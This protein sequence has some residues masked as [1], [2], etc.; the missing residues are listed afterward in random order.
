MMRLSN[1]P[2]ALFPFLDHPA[3]IAYAHRGGA[4]EGE[5]NT[6]PAFE[7]ATALGYTH[8]ET[9]IRASR[10]GVGVVFHDRMLYRVTGHPGP[11]SDYNWSTLSQMRTREGN[12]LLRLDDLL[13]AFPDTFINL[14][15]KS[16]AAVEP[17]IKAIQ[18]VGAIE[19]VCVGS[20]KAARVQRLRAAL[21]YRVCWSPSYSGVARLWFAGFGLFRGLL[22]FPVVQV[23]T[24]FY[25][26]PV[27]T[28]RFMRSAHARGIQ[29]HVWTI[30]EEPE[31]NRL[32]DLGVDGLM[33]D[34]PSLLKDVLQRRGQW[35]D[36]RAR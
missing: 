6:L 9:D 1:R 22:D 31:M 24:D 14:E 28:N 29:V 34:R 12:A 20:F 16:D 4:L 7:R 32:L 18:R 21:G 35:R 8:F 26:L 3:P 5:E 15:V 10:D 23:P 25:G 33:T 2:G 17:M 36:R 19:R 27:V 11:I 13:A 30:S